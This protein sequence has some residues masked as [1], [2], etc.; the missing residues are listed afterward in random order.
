MNPESTFSTDQIKQLCELNDIEYFTHSRI[1]IG[2]M[3]EVYKINDDLVLKIY[4]SE[5]GN[6][7]YQTERAILSSDIDFARPSFVA[8]GETDDRRHYIFMAFVDGPVL[9]HVWHLATDAQREAIVKD[10]STILRKINKIS[11]EFLPSEQDQPW[12]IYLQTRLEDMA[13][14]LLD[15]NIIAQA[16]DSALKNTFS[17]YLDALKTDKMCPVFW[18]VH[19]DNII[20]DD[21][22]KLKALIDLESVDVCAVDYPLFVVTKL[23]DDPKKYATEENEKFAMPEDYKNLRSWY[24][25]YYPEMFKHPLLKDRIKAYILLDTMNLMKE[26]SHVT[27]LVDKFNEQIS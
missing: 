26:W 8:E 23:M 25:K 5:D 9:G 20:V 7:R 3:N 4:K 18:D 13:R 21:N 15:K 27:E 14:E 2:F 11:V 6:K 1:T 16:Q 19:F 12:H 24:E 10:L 17:K 22:F